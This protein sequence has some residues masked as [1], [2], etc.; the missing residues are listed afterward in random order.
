[1]QS[2][3]IYNQ[4]SKKR[5][6]KDGKQSYLCKS[7]NRQFVKDEDRVYLGKIKYITEAVLRLLLYGAGIRTIS[8]SLLVSTKTVFR[9]LIQAKVNL[10]PKKIKYEKIIIDELWSYVQNKKNKQWVIYAICAETKEIIGYVLGKRNISTVKKLKKIFKEKKL[11][12][13]EICFDNWAAFKKVFRDANVS[14]GKKFTNLI[15]GINCYLRHNISRLGRKTCR[16]S[17]NLENHIKHLELIF[18]KMNKSFLAI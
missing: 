15:E 2:F 8:K 10:N 11:I 14:V 9:I 18:D 5:Q 13:S 1:M 17:K 6:K 12:I 16:F 7:C 4:Y 3:L